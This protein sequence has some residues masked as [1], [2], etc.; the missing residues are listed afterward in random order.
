MTEYMLLGFCVLAFMAALAMFY[1]L[2]AL[3]TS[4]DWKRLQICVFSM[5]GFGVVIG[6]LQTANIIF[7]LAFTPDMILLSSIAISLSCLA[8]GLNVSY[9]VDRKSRVVENEET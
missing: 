5:I 3:H 8:I 2:G 1:N 6:M 9:L 7:V 4:E